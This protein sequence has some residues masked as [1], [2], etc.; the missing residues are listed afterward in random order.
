MRGPALPREPVDPD[1]RRRTWGNPDRYR[2]G[3]TLLDWAGPRELLDC[4]A[5]FARPHLAA[6][7]P[8]TVTLVLGALSTV[9]V[10]TTPACA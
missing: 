3:G 6:R 9:V 5:H 4:P 7:R 10:H 8:Q 2:R 1:R